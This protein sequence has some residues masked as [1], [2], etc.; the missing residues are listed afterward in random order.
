[1]NLPTPGAQRQKARFFTEVA[2]AFEF[3]AAYYTLTEEQQLH[4]NQLITKYQ[5]EQK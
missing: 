5:S 4:V 1:M 2:K 3:L